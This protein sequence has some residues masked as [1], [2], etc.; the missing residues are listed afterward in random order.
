M[1]PPPP[2]RPRQSRGAAA[3]LPFLSG[4]NPRE[5]LT[6]TVRYRGGSEAWWRLEARGR[7]WH[8]PGHI[9]LHDALSWVQEGHGGKAREPQRSTTVGRTLKGR[10]RS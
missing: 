5:P 6:I 1:I 2:E 9:A 4:R 10:R 3:S 7:V 8:V